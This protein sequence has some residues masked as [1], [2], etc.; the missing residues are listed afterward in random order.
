[1]LFNIKNKYY[2]SVVIKES[3]FASSQARANRDGLFT[4]FPA[5]ITPRTNRDG[6]LTRLLDGAHREAANELAGHDDTE[7]NHWQRH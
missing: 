6:L 4:V 2:F 1:M 5:Q 3:R 7:Y